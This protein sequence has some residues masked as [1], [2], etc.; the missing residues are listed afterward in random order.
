MRATKCIKMRDPAALK[1][2]SRSLFIFSS[3]QSSKQQLLLPTTT[4][5][6]PHPCT[7]S[8]D[9]ILSPSRP[10]PPLLSTT[11]IYRLPST[12]FKMQFNFNLSTLA[13]ILLSSS[14]ATAFSEP[15]DVAD[16]AERDDIALTTKRTTSCGNQGKI[17]RNK[18]DPKCLP[19]KS[20]GFKS[21]H[22]CQG[23]SYLCVLSGQANCYV[24]P[25]CPRHLSFPSTL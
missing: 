23:K 10:P 1:T 8:L 4:S 12:T 9:C 3:F 25:F 16:I 15:H 24:S 13:I 20:K 18:F 19:S 21:A 22:N 5:L 14:L 17:S 7:A 11:Y 2:A 6:R